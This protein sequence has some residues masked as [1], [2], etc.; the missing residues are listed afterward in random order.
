MRLLFVVNPVSG[1]GAGKK[2]PKKI[3]EL[4][5]YRDIDY[6][7]KFTEYAGHA[8]EIVADVRKSGQYT[9]VV[10]VGGDGTVNE[11]GT[12]LMG[13]DLIFGI[14]SIGSG[15][16]FARHLGYSTSLKKALRQVLCGTCSQVDVMEIN[17]EYSL[18]VSGVGFDA[19]VAHEFNRQKLRGVFSYIYAGLKMWFNYSS[20]KYRITCNGQTVEETCFI[21]S[22]ANSSQFGNNACI[23]PHAS[24]RDG[25]MNVCLLKRPQW[26]NVLLFLFFFMNARVDKLSLYKEFR[27][28]E[29]LIEGDIHKVHIDGEAAFM[30]APVQLKIHKGVLKLVVPKFAKG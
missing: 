11:V 16:G 30:N 21:L 12:S 5:E 1:Y 24:L 6:D 28:E 26:W 19:E 8:R 14:V 23:A 4:A 20:K 17:G 25:L 22:F 29:A 9:H 13:S 3:K 15:N 27:C 18:N 7:I 2:L 10:A